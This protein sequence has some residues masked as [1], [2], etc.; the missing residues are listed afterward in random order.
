[1]SKSKWIKSVAK[2]PI[3]LL[4][5]LI[6]RY[7]AWIGTG[8]RRTSLLVDGDLIIAR[9]DSFDDSEDEIWDFEVSP[10]DP[11]LPPSLPWSDSGV[12]PLG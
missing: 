6:A 12:L 8:G 2:V 10:F 3:N 9:E 4:R 11:S 5:E 7:L 1:M